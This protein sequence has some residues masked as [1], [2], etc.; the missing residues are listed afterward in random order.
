MKLKNDELKLIIKFNTFF[1]PENKVELL[2][3]SENCE[4]LGSKFLSLHLG[5]R[6]MPFKSKIINSE[7]HD[8]IIGEDIDR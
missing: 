7:P 6:T 3:I 1:F 8:G 4:T 5:R 2:G